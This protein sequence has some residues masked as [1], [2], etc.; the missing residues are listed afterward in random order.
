MVILKTIF[1]MLFKIDEIYIWTAYV[2]TYPRYFNYLKLDKTSL[3]SDNLVPRCLV[4][5]LTAFFVKK[6]KK[7]LFLFQKIG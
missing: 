6:E 3:K 2:A 5:Y 7:Y 4:V 1:I